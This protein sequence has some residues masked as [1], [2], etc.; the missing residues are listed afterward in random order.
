MRKNPMHVISKCLND[1]HWTRHTISFHHL[2]LSSTSDHW[3]LSSTLSYWNLSSTL[4]H[5]SWFSTLSYWSWFSTLSHRSWFSRANFNN[6]CRGRLE[7]QISRPN[8]NDS[9]SMTNINDKYRDSISM[10]NIEVEFQWQTSRSWHSKVRPRY[11]SLKSDLVVE[12]RFRRA[13]SC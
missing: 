10:T 5:W 8:F 2:N 7:W 13:M 9:T 3:N 1:F 4:S 11:Y 12:E 6:E